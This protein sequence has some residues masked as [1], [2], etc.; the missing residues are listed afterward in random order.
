LSS[1]RQIWRAGHKIVS[2]VH[3]QVVVETLAD[4]FVPQRVEEIEQLLEFLAVRFLH[5]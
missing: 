5:R 2:F 4:D 3:D 1:I